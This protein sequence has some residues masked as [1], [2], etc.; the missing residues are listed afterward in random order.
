MSGEYNGLYATPVRVALLRAIDSGHG[1]IYYEPEDK[2][3]RD[4]TVG[5]KVTARV[6]E[7]LQREWI[8]A[9]PVTAA[10]KR[11]GELAGRT[12]YRITDVG[13]SVL[14]GQQR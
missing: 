14:K 5:N 9:E 13:R 2:A 8:S 3:V 11:P 6:F 4:K 10:T 12:Y 7:M 1:R